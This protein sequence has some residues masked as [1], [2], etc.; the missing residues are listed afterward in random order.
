[1]A[2]PGSG[3]KRNAFATEKIAALAPM[4]TASESDRGQREER[5]AAQ[6]LERVPGILSPGIDHVNLLRTAS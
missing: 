5:A 6:Q 3:L 2:M 1:M 4:P